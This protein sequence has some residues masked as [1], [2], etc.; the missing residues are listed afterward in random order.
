M[1]TLQDCL[2]LSD[3]TVDEVAAIAAHEHCHEIVAAELGHYLVETPDGRVRIKEMIREDLAAAAKTGDYARTALLKS[4]L[5]H[6]V[7]THGE[8]SPDP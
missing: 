8:L 2:A 6:F 5:K 7:A 3:L 4:V 1:L